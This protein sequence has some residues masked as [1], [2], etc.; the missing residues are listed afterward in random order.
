MLSLFFNTCTHIPKI[1]FCNRLQ[2]SSRLRC[3]APFGFLPAAHQ[4][5]SNF[6]RD[7]LLIRFVLA[8]LTPVQNIF[9]VSLSLPECNSRAIQNKMIAGKL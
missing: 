3:V 9:A 5:Q 7:R 4:K 6:C 2:C 1:Q 8:A